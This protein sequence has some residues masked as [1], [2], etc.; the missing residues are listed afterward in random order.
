M[1]YIHVVR[2]RADAWTSG[3]GD[4]TNRRWASEETILTNL[5]AT[6]PTTKWCGFDDRVLGFCG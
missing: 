3:S 2:R 5:T 6:K 4:F 1:L